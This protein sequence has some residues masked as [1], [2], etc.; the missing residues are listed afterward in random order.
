MSSDARDF[1]T[2]QFE[3]VKFDRRRPDY[4][5]AEAKILSLGYTPQDLLHYFPAF[6]GHMTLWRNLTLY[7][8]YKKT[9]GVSGHIAEV[10]VYKGG[11]SLLFAKLV[12][13]FEPES[14]TLVHGFD[15]FKGTKPSDDDKLLVEGTYLEDE[16]RL[17]E[18]VR[19]QKLDHVLKIHRLDVAK[20]LDGFFA[21]HAHMRFKLVFLDAGVYD[22]VSSA[23]RAFWPRLTPGGLLV[24]D[25]YNHEL[26]LGEVRAV[27]E[28]LANEKIETIP[29][30]WMPNA[31]IQKPW[32]RGA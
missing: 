3:S 15:W 14:L 22:V 29:N 7:E 21:E 26:A 8:L 31:Y 30:S 23:I 13:I 18:L 2:G 24:L 28:L 20:E 12:E 6:V 19:L 27:A 1:R 17:R 25:Q 16:A 5:A 9:L 11:T 10:G 32:S 4:L